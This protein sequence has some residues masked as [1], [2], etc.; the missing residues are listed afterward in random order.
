[1]QPREGQYSDD[2]TA[3][4]SSVTMAFR[5]LTLKGLSSCLLTQIYS[6]QQLEV[7]RQVN[8]VNMTC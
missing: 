7:Y 8:M 3:T 4:H 1:M 2:C 6:Q 5:I